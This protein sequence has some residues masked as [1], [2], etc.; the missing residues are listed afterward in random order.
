MGKKLKSTPAR[1]I[2]RVRELDL[3]KS[4]DKLKLFKGAN[5]HSTVD[6]SIVH[7][8]EF[9]IL[10]RTKHFHLKRINNA[11]GSFKIMI[12]FAIPQMNSI[13]YLQ[14]IV[15]QQDFI[16]SIIGNF[17][18]NFFFCN[19][20]VNCFHL[21]YWDICSDEWICESILFIRDDQ[22]IIGLLFILKLFIQI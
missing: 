14:F 2:F 22:L 17:S 8:H 7:W 4:W 6:V 20:F 18:M 16:C 1:Y 9:E 15:L 12:P 21:T 19:E 5:C 11:L 13:Y 10:H 3:L